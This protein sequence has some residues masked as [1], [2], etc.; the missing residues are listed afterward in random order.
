M[1]AKVIIGKYIRQLL[2][3]GKR[4]ILPGFGN[5][6]IKEVSGEVPTSG[7]RISPPGPAV[8]FDEKYSKDD[9]LLASV[10]ASGENVDPGEAEQQ[11]LELVDAIRFALDKGEPYTLPD[12]GTFTR[13]SEGKVHFQTD[14][15]WVL[16][17]EQ[18]GLDSMDLLELEDIPEEQDEP[19]AEEPGGEKVTEKPGGKK[20]A[21]GSGGEKVPEKGKEKPAPDKAGPERPAPEKARPEKPE[22]EKAHSEAAVPPEDKG[23]EHS[24]GKEAPVRRT[25]S[26][27]TPEPREPVARTGRR[28]RRWR[29]IWIITGVLI[30]I[31]A[32]LIFVPVERTGEGKLRLGGEGILLRE[33][34]TQP[35]ETPVPGPEESTEA[36]A[37][38]ETPDGVQ[39]E[40]GAQAQGSETG[41]QEEAEVQGETPAGVQGETPAGVQ[42]ET[43]AGVQGEGRYFIIAGS[44]RSL[45]NASEMQDQLKARGYPSEVM[46]TGD[47]MY[48]VSVASYATKQE[49]LRALEEIRAE[50]DL[51]NSWLLS[52]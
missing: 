48:R 4:V 19:A 10:Y 18:F 20:A 25:P 41:A 11:V 49:A 45:Q 24:P 23:S 42:G 7:G 35:L 16:E 1:K 46:V 40:A 9:G 37:Q 36:G 2:E 26:W 29:V 14:P 12:T 51:Q 39:G 3:E 15:A 38:G 6:Q 8:S 34:G 30:V 13:D 27:A 47:R 5:L 21:E 28:A 32:L 22:P 33:K 50:T 44:F 43:P 31:L 17:P 52:R